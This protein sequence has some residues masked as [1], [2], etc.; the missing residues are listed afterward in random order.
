MSDQVLDRREIGIPADVELIRHETE[1]MADSARGSM[2]EAAFRA[3]A[4]E[5]SRAAAA[6]HAADARDAAA[7]AQMW[8]SLHNQG[9]HFGPGEPEAKWDGMTWLRTDE[10]ARKILSFRRWDAMADGSALFPSNSLF[11]S[12]SL[13]PADRGVWTDFTV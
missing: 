8:A 7:E 12:D 11:P 10:E 1:L 3:E 2:E 13:I 4:A 6:A 9:V 5:A